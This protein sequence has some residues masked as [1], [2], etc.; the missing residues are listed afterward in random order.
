MSPTSEK[1]ETTLFTRA[2]QSINA[3]RYTPHSA[4]LAKTKPGEKGALFLTARFH[5]NPP[6]QKT[7]RM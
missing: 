6:P 1:D 7:A 5:A 4:S 2:S 3:F